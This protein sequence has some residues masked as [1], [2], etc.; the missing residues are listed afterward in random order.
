MRYDWMD[1]QLL[2]KPG[3]TR[4]YKV[5]WD[6]VRFM[7]DG[8]MFAAQGGNKAGEPILTLKCA[9]DWGEALCA[10]YPDITPGYYTDKRH[11]ISVLRAGEVPDDLMRQL[12]DGAYDSLLA[13]LSKKRQRELREAA[14]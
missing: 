8:K 5:A 2:A 3:V 4:D 14:L 1:E 11:W 13:T 10:A 7:V 6:M 12:L 9:P